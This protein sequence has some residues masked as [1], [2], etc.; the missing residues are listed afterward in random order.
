[1]IASSAPIRVPWWLNTP[2]GTVQSV[3]PKSTVQPSGIPVAV[4]SWLSTSS[5]SWRAVRASVF[6]KVITGA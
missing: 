4:P 3:R 2:A 6:V 1:V 5:S